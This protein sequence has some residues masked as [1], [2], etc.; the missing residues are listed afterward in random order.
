MSSADRACGPCFTC[1]KVPRS[2]F[3]GMVGWRGSDHAKAPHT[4]ARQSHGP[5]SAVGNFWVLKARFG[6]IAEQLS[7]SS[8][9]LQPDP[10]A[11]RAASCF[12]GSWHQGS[13]VR[14]GSRW[15][16]HCRCCARWHGPFSGCSSPT[17]S[18][19][20]D[21]SGALAAPRAGGWEQV[22]HLGTWVR[23][24]PGPTG[25]L[26]GSTCVSLFSLEEMFSS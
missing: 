21:A 17:T 3:S 1:C 16:W 14:G 2:V 6:A 24:I 9:L 22:A 11:G 26:F 25:H 23:I 20:G 8:S 7:P 4:W 18:S 5:S 10:G 19:R 15:W 13:P 12:S